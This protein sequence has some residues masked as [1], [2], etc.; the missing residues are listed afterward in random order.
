MTLPVYTCVK[1]FAGLIGKALT[2][3]GHRVIN[4]QEIKTTFMCKGS[5]EKPSVRSDPPRGPSTRPPFFIKDRLV[6]VRSF[7]QQLRW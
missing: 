5:I 2:D 6:Y 4:K 1:F 3:E 7:F